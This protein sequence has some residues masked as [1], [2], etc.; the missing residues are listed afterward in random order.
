MLDEA[1]DLG[2]ELGDLEIRAGARAWR[3]ITCMALGAVEE[4]RRELATLLE[5]AGRTRQPFL[6]SSAELIGS[7]IALFEGKLDEAE[8]RAGRAHASEPVLSGRDGSGSYGI[9]MFSIR[10][11]QGRLSELAP[12]VRALAEGDGSPGAWRPGLIALLVELGMHDEARRE[13]AW[14]RA[15]GLEPFRESLWVASLTYLTEACAALGDE[16]VAALIRPDLESYA[17]ATVS[18]GHGVAFY[19]ATDRYRGM[20]AATVRD[21]EGAERHFDS[22]LELNRRMGAGTW[23]AHTAYEYGRMLRARGRAEDRPRVAALLDEAVALAERIGMAALL[24][25]IRVIRSPASMTVA[26]PDGLSPRELDILR[27]VTRGLSNRQIGEQL[28]IS[29]HTAANHVRSIL[30]KTSSANRTEAAGYAHRHGLAEALG[31]G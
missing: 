12:V 2:D 21:W 3:A 20:L 28:V 17:D 29:E 16:E 1:R 23:L 13:L 14:I 18:V 6:L 9:Q 31:R 15:H 11:E 26:L 27:L 30:R 4:G 8:A 24:A 10:R 5:I 7:A 22:A 25:R 19:G